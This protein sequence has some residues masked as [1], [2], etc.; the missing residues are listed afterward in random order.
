MNGQLKAESYKKFL[1]SIF[2]NTIFEKFMQFLPSNKDKI[3]YKNH[4]GSLS[5]F[6]NNLNEH[7]HESS[8]EPCTDCEGKGWEKIISKKLKKSMIFPERKMDL[9]GWIGKL[10]F[11]KDCVKEIMII[12]ES[13]TSKL[14]DVEIPKFLHLK[15][16]R[17]INCVYETGTVIR[18]PSEFV[19]EK[20]ILK[21]GSLRFWNKVNDIAQA[22][23][24]PIHKFI[25][26]LY[27]TDVA[28]CN[29]EK[30]RKL[31]ITCARK[32]LL[33]E[34]H[35]IKPKIIITHGN[36]AFM[37]L[38]EILFNSKT[39]FFDKKYVS[40]FIWGKGDNFITKIRYDMHIENLTPPK[41][42]FHLFPFPHL[43][44][45]TRFKNEYWGELFM[46][47]ATIIKTLKI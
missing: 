11:S 39:F 40:S 25:E 27:I 10:D 16:K 24:L 2:G 38:F 33:K 3:E 12:G 15:K 32:H 26:K 21:T 5:D 28:H 17:L 22:L 45:D 46:K 9:P 44:G 35:L 23:G 42:D 18:Q 30:R 1:D 34:I 36:I 6:I 31:Y 47:F 19:S 43:S 4:N 41:Y 29:C 14:A 37:T 8:N 20:E 7:Q 13:I